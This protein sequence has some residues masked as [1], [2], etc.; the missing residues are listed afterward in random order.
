MNILVSACLLGVNCRYDGGSI[1]VSQELKKLI[2]QHNLIPICPEQL[3]GLATPRPPVELVNGR[4]MTQDACDMTEQFVLGAYET[5]E[6]AKLFN[7]KY[8]ILKERSPS[9][10]SLN[11]YSGNFDGTL[12]NGKGL[13]TKLL[14]ENDMI[15]LNESQINN[16]FIT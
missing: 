12:L 3:G 10:G 8:A 14:R 6:I 13:T 7:C 2:G 5:L 9:C 16:Y 15:V 4:A 1:S 11:I